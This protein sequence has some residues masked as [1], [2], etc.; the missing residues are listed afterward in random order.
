MASTRAPPKWATQETPTT[1]TIE[2]RCIHSLMVNH[3]RMH[4]KDVGTHAKL[5]ILTADPFLLVILS[6]KQ[7]LALS[8]D[9]TGGI[10]ATHAPS[11]QDSEM[12][13]SVL[14][15]LGHEP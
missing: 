7:S 14:R 2:Q 3:R 12:R 1:T 9:M 8:V 4:S 6:R 5:A 11:F 15:L 10:L 13:P